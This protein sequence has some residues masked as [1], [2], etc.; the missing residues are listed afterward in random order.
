MNDATTRCVK[1]YDFAC[2]EPDFKMA[3][4]ERNFQIPPC[5]GI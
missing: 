1:F 4:A 2:A 5:G 3:F